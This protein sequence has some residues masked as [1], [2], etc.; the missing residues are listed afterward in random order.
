MEP[1]PDLHVRFDAPMWLHEASGTWHFVT[2]PF[3]VA[4]EI[5]AMVGTRTRGFG[6]VRVEVTIGGS[7]WRTSLFPDTKAESYV[8]PIKKPVR[9]AE[10]LTLG[11]PVSVSLTVLREQL[12]N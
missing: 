11:E 12:P 1:Q 5:E 9:L 6:S 10:G 7:I 8:L 4:D 3:S 2:V